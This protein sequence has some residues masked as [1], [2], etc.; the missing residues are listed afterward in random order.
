MLVVSRTN[1]IV[2]SIAVRYCTWFEQQPCQNAQ[3]HPKAWRLYAKSLRSGAVCVHVESSHVDEDLS[4][5]YRTGHN[6]MPYIG[7]FDVLPVL[8]T[9]V[10][11][12][13]LGEVAGVNFGVCL[14]DE[15][16]NMSFGQAI[17][18]FT[19]APLSVI[20]GDRQQLVVMARSPPCRQ[21][22][23]NTG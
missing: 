3:G 9:T 16:S 23:S 10:D 15:G 20:F 11:Q 18:L 21:V 2:N 13:L 6:Y 12:V 7:R 22:F 19:L 1:V 5:E 17:A 14:V 4:A 8:F